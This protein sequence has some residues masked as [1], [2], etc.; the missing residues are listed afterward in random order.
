V[1]TT[2]LPKDKRMHREREA[3]LFQLKVATGIRLENN[4]SD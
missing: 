4:I 1:R 2:R 3:R